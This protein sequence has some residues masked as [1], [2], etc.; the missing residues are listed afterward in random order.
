MALLGLRSHDCLISGK[1][2]T[3]RTGLSAGEC[4]ATIQESGDVSNSKPL[5]LD[6]NPAE[7]TRFE[8]DTSNAL[9]DSLRDQE[10]QLSR[11]RM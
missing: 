2:D 4:Y 9:F 8:E 1:Y 10:H 7:I 6:Q 5:V 11:K 3:G